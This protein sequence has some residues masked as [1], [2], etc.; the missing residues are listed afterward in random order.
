MA[1]ELDAP[2]SPFLPDVNVVAG[3][4]ALAR[5]DVPAALDSFRQSNGAEAAKHLCAEVDT[6][7]SYGIPKNDFLL[8]LRLI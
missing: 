8:F 1:K 6:L 3:L 7:L 2:S 4:A 5:M